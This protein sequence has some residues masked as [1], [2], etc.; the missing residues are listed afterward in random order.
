M[1]MTK[2]L[3][4]KL[5]AAEADITRTKS[6]LYKFIEQNADIVGRY[7]ELKDEHESAITSAKSLFAAHVDD[8]GDKWAGFSVR[9]T[10]QLDVNAL[11]AAL[12]K[13]ADKYIKVEY[14]VDRQLYLRDAQDGLIPQS[15][16]DKVE[17][18]VKI[19]VV[20]PKS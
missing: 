3:R 18:D 6:D 11:R 20:P 7:L 4:A 13:K 2:L 19:A 5:D 9:R 10:V 16:T 14:S 8:V 17:G 1:T 15:V 12:G